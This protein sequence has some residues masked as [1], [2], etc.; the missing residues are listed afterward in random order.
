MLLFYILLLLL[1]LSLVLWPYERV[2]LERIIT[3]FKISRLCRKRDIKFKVLNRVYPFSFNTSNEFDFI[4]RID[5]TVIPVKFLSS[6]W[7]GSTVIFDHSGRMCTVRKYVMPLSRD[8]KKKIKTVKKYQ[9]IPNMR[10]SKKIIGE[11]FRCF[12][13]FLNAPSF[14][15]VLY[16]DERGNI[17][18]FYDGAHKILGCNLVDFD[19]LE[20]FVLANRNK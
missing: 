20:T 9:K 11:R 19:V 14:E 1:V 12:P 13:I 7:G 3:V 10:I 5:K 8:E 15:N 6:T 4:L 16:R 2:M 17:S 18:S